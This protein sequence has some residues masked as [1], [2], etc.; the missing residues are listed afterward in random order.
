MNASLLYEG[1]TLVGP[2]DEDEDEFG[3]DFF[4]EYDDFDELDDMDMFASE[5]DDLEEWDEEEDEFESFGDDDAD[6]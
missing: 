4:D 5:D 1:D 3:L 2:E 6:L